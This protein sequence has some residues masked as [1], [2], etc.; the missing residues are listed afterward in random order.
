MIDLDAICDALA[1]RF[2]A[3]TIATPTGASAM[4]KAYAKVPKNIAAFPAVMLEVQDGTVVANPGQWKHEMNIDVLFIL[5]K[6]LADPERSEKQRQ[7]WLGKLLAATQGALKITLAAA[8]GYSVDKALPTGWEWTEFN[9]GGDEHDG[10][11]VHYTVY[12]T[13]TATLVP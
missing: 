6:R 10:I 1:A 5:P 8:S 11:R 9:I 12:V 4:R 2:A 3:G 13:E 7:L